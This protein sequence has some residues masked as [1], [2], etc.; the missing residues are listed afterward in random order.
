MRLLGAIWAEGLLR[1]TAAAKVLSTCHGATIGWRHDVAGD[2]ADAPGAF[3]PFLAGA[4]V[5]L[6]PVCFIDAS[7]PDDATEPARQRVR[8]LTRAVAWLRGALPFWPPSPGLSCTADAGVL[9]RR[10]LR[11]AAWDMQQQAF[12]VL[13]DG[14]SPS[15]PEA[16][17]ALS[18]LGAA[19][20]PDHAG[21]FGRGVRCV[22][23]AG[24]DG[25]WAEAIAP[26]R[27]SLD[28]LRLALRASLI[29]A[30][31]AWRGGDA[32]VLDGCTGYGPWQKTGSQ[33]GPGKGP[34]TGPGGLTG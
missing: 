17:A 11:E 1:R 22:I 24:H 19:P 28:A 9:V 18:W 6:G 23:L 29:A 16:K 21:T 34:E 8:G 14:A 32:A 26:D 2:D 27:A 7:A 4:L 30:G 12:F 33:T 10:G 25:E 13:S 15:R 5:S 20:R 3:A 31:L